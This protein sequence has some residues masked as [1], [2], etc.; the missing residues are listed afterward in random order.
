MTG[1]TSDGGR[2]FWILITRESLWRQ[3]RLNGAWAFHRF[4]MST[5][6]RIRRGDVAFVYLTRESERIPGRIVSA[7]T[8]VAPGQSLPAEESRLEFYPYRVP[9]RVLADLSPYL[10][11]TD[12]VGSLEFITRKAQYGLFLQGKS[13][14]PLSLADAEAVLS[15]ATERVPGSARKRLRDVVP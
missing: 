12:V 9:F 3:F 2:A 10:E 14:I 7:V 11:F 6:K 1:E 13:A 4:S 5:A 8:I 15:A